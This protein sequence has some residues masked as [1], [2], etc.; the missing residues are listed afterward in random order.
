MDGF[1]ASLLGLDIDEQMLT[2]IDAHWAGEISNAEA[3]RLMARVLA[4][5]QE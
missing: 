5:S 1:A 3:C 2:I 4:D